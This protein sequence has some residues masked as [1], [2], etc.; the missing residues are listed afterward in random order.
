M[1]PFRTD[2]LSPPGPEKRDSE[3][4]YSEGLGRKPAYQ[5]ARLPAN[6]MYR[7]VLTPE[8]RDSRKL[9][10]TAYHIE[11]WTY[12]ITAII[13]LLPLHYFHFDA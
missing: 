8:K 7:P 13:E 6:R 1:L 12:A 4:E 10:F 9:V 11:N 2:A 3:T 5:E